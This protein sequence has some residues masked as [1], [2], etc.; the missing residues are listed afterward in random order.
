MTGF[1][2]LLAKLMAK[3]LLLS[4]NHNDFFLVLT[5]RQVVTIGRVPE[6]WVG[7]KGACCI[8]VGFGEM[9]LRGILHTTC[10]S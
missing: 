6:V 9:G 10:K 8:G 2:L 4:L 1:R 7:V 5:V 3:Q